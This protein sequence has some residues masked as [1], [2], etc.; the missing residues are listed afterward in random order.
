MSSLFTP[1]VQS[2]E[3]CLGASLARIVTEYYQDKQHRRCGWFPLVVSCPGA[4]CQ[5][6]PGF[7][8]LL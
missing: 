6:V 7:L 8:L 1:E 4:V 2:Q 5:T 3:A